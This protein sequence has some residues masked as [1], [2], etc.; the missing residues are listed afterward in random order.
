[1]KVRA[2]GYAM[3]CVYEHKLDSFVS[4]EADTYIDLLISKI[5]E[6]WGKSKRNRFQCLKNCNVSLVSKLPIAFVSFLSF[7]V[8]SSWQNCR[9]PSTRSYGT[10]KIFDIKKS[11]LG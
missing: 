7:F 10:I 1:M 5:D 8:D 9:D 6:I 3:F 11:S 2:T 4:Y